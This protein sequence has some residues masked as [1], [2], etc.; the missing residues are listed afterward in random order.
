MGDWTHWHLGWKKIEN[1]EE[2]RE[3][4]DRKGTN[5]GWSIE[6]FNPWL[7][8]EQVTAS[9]VGR[10]SIVNML[11]SALSVKKQDAGGDET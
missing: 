1:D 6:E 5:I 2:S 9:S 3:T 7:P 4:S 11:R 8:G 10:V